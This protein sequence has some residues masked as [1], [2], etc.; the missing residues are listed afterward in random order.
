MAD[1][2]ISQDDIKALLAAAGIEAADYELTPLTGGANNRVYRL[3]A[4]N[5]TYLL[6]EYFQHPQDLRDRVTAEFLF[7]E[8]A[9]K[10]GVR[11]L[12]KPFA[13]VKNDTVKSGLYEYIDGR[14]LKVGEI[15]EKRVK[16]ALDFFL[17]I[18]S[19]RS[20]A[21]S[22]K[23]PAASEACFSIREHLD[24]VE[25][26]ISRLSKIQINS[27]IDFEADKFI[28]NNLLP[29]W[30]A[31]R[32]FIIESCKS[33]NIEISSMIAPAC[34]CISPSDFGFHNALLAGDGLLRFIDFEYAGWDDPVK[35]CCD[36]FCQ[37]QL[38]V[39]PD[40]IKWF[41]GGV[42]NAFPEYHSLTEK[43]SIL[44][45]LYQ[46]KWCCIML[47]E[48]LPVSASRRVFAEKEDISERK[49]RQ[50]FKAGETLKK[51]KKELS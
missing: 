31:C 21:E 14:K 28:K 48:F 10:N 24:C 7:S 36:F 23:L 5:A 41:T 30:L 37:P 6:K 44:F 38:P 42:A 8:F 32:D 33:K 20:N 15:D 27:D 11:S 34:R 50:L 46:I 16:E 4:G 22:S 12:P 25:K 29:E 45:P 35:T 17:Q 9:W 39:N 49:I 26:R 47:N 3:D 19:M 18:N 1:S 43:V 2:K 51:L 40:N 13:Y